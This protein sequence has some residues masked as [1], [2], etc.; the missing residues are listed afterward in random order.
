M[1][2]GVLALPYSISKLG[3]ILGLA[4]ILV[5]CMLNAYTMN[6][7]C[8]IALTRSNAST[9]ADVGG[10]VGNRTR[11]V[12]SFIASLF[13]AAVVCANYLVATVSLQQIFAGAGVKICGFRCGCLLGATT[14]PLLQIRTLHQLGSLGVVGTMCILVP[15]LLVL[16]N[17]VISDG[18]SPEIDH[19]AAHLYPVHSFEIDTANEFAIVLGACLFQVLWLIARVNCNPD[20]PLLLFCSFHAAFDVSGSHE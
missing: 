19:E 5:I 8:R 20:A 14:L 15:I 12:L 3:W 4:S 2:I 6:L 17:F 11:I 1:G 7:L 13:M 18:P 10:F 9:Y 16:A